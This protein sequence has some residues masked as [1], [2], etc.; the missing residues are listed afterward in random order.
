MSAFEDS[1]KMQALIAAIEGLYKGGEADDVTYD[2]VTKPSFE[3]R[4]AQIIDDYGNIVD[5]TAQALAA[6]GD[7]EAAAT[8]A[9]LSGQIY[10][11]TADA[12]SNGV[13]ALSALVA[14][15]GGT[16]DTYALGFSG[17]GDGA[18]GWFT[19]V[20]GQVSSYGITSRGKGY[21]SPPTVSFAA[22]PGLTGASATAV[23]AP[24]RQLGDFFSVPGVTSYLDLYRVDPGPVATYLD[25]SLPLSSLVS[26]LAALQPQLDLRSARSTEVSDL[27]VNYD[28]DRWITIV[29]DRKYNL[30]WGVD[31][32]GRFRSA[33]A[34]LFTL[35]DPVRETTWGVADEK[36]LSLIST[37]PASKGAPIRNVALR[38]EF[39]RRVAWPPI[40]AFDGDSR[41]DQGV[42]TYRSNTFGIPYWLSFLSNGRFDFRDELNFGVG[43][44]TSA[45][46]LGRVE[47]TIAACIA[48]GCTKLVALFSLNDRGSIAT[49]P[50]SSAQSTIANLEAYQ[51]AVLDAGIDL[52][53]VAEIP[54]GNPA[55]QA[56]NP[57]EIDL[58]IQASATLNHLAVR[59]WQLAQ[60]FSHPRVSVADPF[61]RLVDSTALAINGRAGVLKD[62]KHQS[63]IGAYIIAQAVL[64]IIEQHLPPLGRL[65]SSA[66]DV[67]D[68]TNPRGSLLGTAT[69]MWG[70]GGT[71]SGGGTH[72]GAMPDGWDANIA[73]GVNVAFSSVHDSEG[74]SWLQ[75]VV[76]GSPSAP[77][78][79]TLSASAVSVAPL[80][81]GV[82]F[83]AVVET[84]VDEGHSGLIANMLRPILTMSDTSTPHS[85][86]GAQAFLPTD[87]NKYL[88]DVP[89]SGIAV[90]PPR[91][92]P[93]GTVSAA[94]L[95]LQ[96]VGDTSGAAGATVRWRLPSLNLHI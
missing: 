31:E 82:E 26:A 16:D 29:V 70:S 17:D 25:V 69:M 87:I 76:T 12:L 53:W 63:S 74:A 90:T 20:A 60:P 34:P 35:D 45:Q 27:F 38:N 24:N 28:D 57:S 6:K 85:A 67:Y 22:A 55:W 3:K 84:E 78:W 30:G 62:A 39:N 58:G 2:E 9:A 89:L 19:V 40:I 11:T 59:R 1:Q 68:V 47:E 88:P 41:V 75:A 49:S 44:Q 83:I 56:A 91:P 51:A 52:I 5:L 94:V 54:V 42:D 18:A 14:G 93:P 36:G 96:L 43:G 80:V 8:V 66:S 46:V 61:P 73:E 95:Q 48:A 33:G 64:P 7:A 71:F 79:L 92:V 86:A 81:T 77:Q 10:D 50:G 32:K 13:Y 15:S 4:F 72:S 37:G 21:T 65:T 23:I